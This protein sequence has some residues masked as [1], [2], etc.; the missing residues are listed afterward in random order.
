MIEGIHYDQSFAPVAMIDT[1]R[2][3]LSIGSAQGK[4]A[5]ISD[6]RNAFQNTIESDPS[7]CTYSTLPHFFMEYLRLRWAT[8][9]GLPAV[10]Q[11]PSAF[12]IQKCCSFQGQKD[13]D[14]KFYQLMHKYMKHI[15]LHRS[16]S[17]HG[18]FVW[19]QPSSELFLA[20]ALATDDCI[21]LCDDR[22]QFLD[23]KE[24]M[25][26]MFEVTLQEGAILR[27]LNVR[28]IQSPAGISID[29]TDHIL[30]TIVM[31]FLKNQGTSELVS[32][33]SPFPT[34]SSL[35]QRLYEAPVLVGAALKKI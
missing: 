18:V 27:F 8:Y 10:E 4:Q 31:S 7:K 23:L 14:Q 33:T 19:K 11:D 25:E 30:D 17:D 2:I 6:I 1:I 21:V 20:L 29:Q 28:I 16:I 32:I 3:V 15:G 12:V 13:V 22:V 34:D 24:K 9:P 35:E 5:Y 26:K